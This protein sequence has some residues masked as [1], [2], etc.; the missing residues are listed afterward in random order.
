M[1]ARRQAVSWKFLLLA[2]SVTPPAGRFAA[3]ECGFGSSGG[4]DIKL[5]PAQ[6]RAHLRAFLREVVGR[7]VTLVG[8]S[9]GGAMAIDYAVS[10]PEE[11][12]KLVLVDAQVGGRLQMAGLS[13]LTAS[14][15]S[16]AW[17]FILLFRGALLACSTADAAAPR[18]HAKAEL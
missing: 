2:D 3:A 12:H 1:H 9:L 13:A 15:A 5:G 14:G 4:A 7:P 17:L 18:W 11:L 8:T 10:H 16:F 6:K